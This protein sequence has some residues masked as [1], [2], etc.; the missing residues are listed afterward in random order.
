MDNTLSLHFWDLLGKVSIHFAV[1]HSKVSWYRMYSH[2]SL[3]IFVSNLVFHT[4]GV[5]SVW[6]SIV[7]RTPTRSLTRGQSVWD[8]FYNKP[9][10]PWYP[11]IKPLPQDI[12]GKCLVDF[13]SVVPSNLFIKLAILHTWLR[14]RSWCGSSVQVTG[15]RKTFYHQLLTQ[16]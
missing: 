5:H 16:A 4:S 14:P 3:C 9:D 15:H 6:Y 11:Y 8:P 1:I 10:E 13:Y 2:N 7:T 12:W